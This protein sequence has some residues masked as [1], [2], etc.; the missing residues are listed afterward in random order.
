M[1]AY[2]VTWLIAPGLICVI[3]FLIVRD[4]I[5]KW[6]QIWKILWVYAFLILIFSYFKVYYSYSDPVS[7]KIRSGEAHLP[8]EQVMVGDDVYSVW[9]DGLRS[10]HHAMRKPLLLM[11]CSGITLAVLGATRPKGKNVAE[12]V[13]A[14]DR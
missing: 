12:Q 11:L 6:P 10:G 7:A 13:A 8:E 4:P 5:F 2:E 14:S 1:N 9:F 3:C